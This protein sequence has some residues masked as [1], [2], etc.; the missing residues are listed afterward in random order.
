MLLKTSEIYLYY[1]TIYSRGVAGYNIWY[2]FVDSSWRAPWCGLR[3]DCLGLWYVDGRASMPG[4]S[5]GLWMLCR[6][7]PAVLSV[8]HCLERNMPAPGP[9]RPEE[10]GHPEVPQIDFKRQS[11]DSPGVQF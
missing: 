3:H 4:H 1:L 5:S 11:R 8:C 10:H 7:L 2:N 9:K 6:A